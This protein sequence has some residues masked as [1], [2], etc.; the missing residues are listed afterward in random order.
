MPRSHPTL[1]Y[2]HLQ[3]FTKGTGRARDEGC[4]QQYGA[5]WMERFGGTCRPKDEQQVLFSRDKR[6]R[7]LNQR[8]AVVCLDG[9]IGSIAGPYEGK[10]NDHVIV[11]VSGLEGDVRRV[12]SGR[13]QLFLSGDQACK[14]LDGIFGPCRWGRSLTGNKASFDR[15]LS[16]VRIA[17]G[18]TDPESVGIRRLRHATTSA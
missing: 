16:S 13:R 12:C 7:G 9:P 3:Q 17:V 8:A 18:Q 15:Q 5:L 14:H 4:R 6:R 1:K 11:R 10:A 2:Q